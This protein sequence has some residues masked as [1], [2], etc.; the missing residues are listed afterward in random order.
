VLRYIQIW[1]KWR[2]GV[3]LARRSE[4]HLVLNWSFFITSQPCVLIF[5]DFDIFSTVWVDHLCRSNC[6]FWLFFMKKCVRT[7]PYILM[8]IPQSLACLLFTI[9]RFQYCYDSLIWT[10]FERVIALFDSELFMLFS[11]LNIIHPLIERRLFCN[12]FVRPF[13]LS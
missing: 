5:G 2:S 3:F 10:I 8:G 1:H 12:H 4:Q 13:T 9:F 11:T 7:T 6:P